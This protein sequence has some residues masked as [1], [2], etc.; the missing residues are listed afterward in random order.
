MGGRS[1]QKCSVTPTVAPGGTVIVLVLWFYPKPLLTLI[2]RGVL[3][4]SSIVSPPGPTQ[5]AGLLGGK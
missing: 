3:D 5:I 4:L 1:R 2:D